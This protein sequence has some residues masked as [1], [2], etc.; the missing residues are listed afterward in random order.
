MAKGVT[1][2]DQKTGKSI[3][4]NEKYVESYKEKGYGT[5]KP[6]KTR[7]NTSQYDSET[8][9]TKYYNSDGELYKVSSGDKTSKKSSS[10]GTMSVIKERAAQTSGNTVRTTSDAPPPNA[11]SIYMTRPD[12]S[13]INVSAGSY[14]SFINKGYTYDGV[15]TDDKGMYDR[16]GNLIKTKQYNTS[17]SDDYDSSNSSSKN[18]NSSPTFDS[19]AIMDMIIAMANS[20]YDQQKLNL[21]KQIA[22]VLSNYNAQLGRVEQ[23]YMPTYQ[24]IDQ[25]NYN[26]QEATK[27]AMAKAGLLGTG[28]GEGYN[29]QNAFK[30]AGM[31]QDVDLQKQGQYD[32]INKSI[33]DVQ[34]DMQYDLNNID[35]EKINFINAQQLQEAKDLRSIELDNYWKNR[36]MNL[37][38]AQFDFTKDS[39][40]RQFS[41][42]DRQQIFAE[43]SWEKT[44][45]L[46]VDKFKAQQK[47]FA[48]S[49]G[50]E[51]DKFARSKFEFD[52]TLKQRNK[53]FDATME[54]N[55]EQL[56]QEMKMNE[57]QLEAS[58]NNA[59]LDYRSSMARLEQEAFEYN[60]QLE[61]AWAQDWLDESRRVDEL[62]AYGLLNDL[63]ADYMRG[64]IKTST[65]SPGMQVKKLEMLNN[66]FG[67][68]Y[69][70]VNNTGGTTGWTSGNR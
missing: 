65:L 30:Y 21:R 69:A 1:M 39:F 36:Q 58:I 42:Q 48:K 4:V 9:Q 20:T 17:S 66:A 25:A 40:E 6:T 44:Y 61:R 12:G 7:N 3:S 37:Q 49:W 15:R 24:N 29:Q 43:T 54:W 41:L 47:Q 28:I 34:R 60:R 31:R 35:L 19:K 50:L 5:S 52:E 53:E 67:S 68:G 26:Q 14:E 38:E 18:N 13:Q 32:A 45:Q 8:N 27:A 59:M 22:S 64:A 57:K 10:S 55:E 16:N 62:I 56:K 70:S 2:Y 11:I 23:D 51:N 33:A 63:G 46:D